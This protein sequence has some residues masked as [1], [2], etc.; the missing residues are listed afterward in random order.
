MPPTNVAAAPSGSQRYQLIPEA[1]APKLGQRSQGLITYQV[2]TNDARQDLFLRIAKNDGGGYV[3]DEAVSLHQLRRCINEHPA[4]QPMRAMAF[5]TAFIGRSS[6]QPTFAAAVMLGEG[7][8][9]RD[10]QRPGVL[11]DGVSWHAWAEAQM[12]TAAGDL[13]EVMVG[14]A[15]K[16]PVTEAAPAEQAAGAEQ[17][18][19][20]A[21]VEDP[22]TP[23]D[24]DTPVTASGKPRKGR[25]A[26]LKRE[27]DRH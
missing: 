18:T 27:R 19:T 12:A 23:A 16:L 20:E 17:A 3:S 2:L 9:Q 8:L 1:T 11:V 5:K 24:G 21:G 7:L 15:P 10:P 14:K 26:V 22:A 13:A 25:G 6:N 4:E